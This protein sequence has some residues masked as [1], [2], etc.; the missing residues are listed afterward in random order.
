M[1]KI[2]TISQKLMY[3]DLV[4]D[5]VVSRSAALGRLLYCKGYNIISRLIHLE[6]GNLKVI[7]KW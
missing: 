6:T 4:S 7:G 2:L 3:E 1:D 5:I